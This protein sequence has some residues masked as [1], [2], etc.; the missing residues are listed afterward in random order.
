MGNN[1]VATEAEEKWDADT[2][3]KREDQRNQLRKI[4]FEAH[5][6]GAVDRRDAARRLLANDDLEYTFDEL[7]YNKDYVSAWF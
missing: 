4:I 5:E 3:K 1:T 2:L 6:A 7:P